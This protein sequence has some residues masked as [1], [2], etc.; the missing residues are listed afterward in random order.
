[1][2]HA[3][4][5]RLGRGNYWSAN[6]LDWARAI[7]ANVRAAA[8][9]YALTNPVEDFADTF[10]FSVLGRPL[11]YPTNGY[12]GSGTGIPSRERRDALTVAINQLKQP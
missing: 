1:M 3:F 12:P 2:G 5:A 4:D 9:N 7:A 11:Q 8:S 10:V 6:S